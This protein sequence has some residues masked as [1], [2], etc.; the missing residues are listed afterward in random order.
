MDRIAAPNR[1]AACLRAITLV[2]LA[3]ATSA[4]SFLQS[5]HLLDMRQGSVRSDIVRQVS[6]GGYELAGGESVEFRDWYSPAFPDL[7]LSFLTKIGEDTGIIWGFSTGERGEKYRISPGLKLGFVHAIHPTSD[8][9]LTLTA[10]VQLGSRLRERTC[11]A[12]YGEVGG[13]ERVNCR[14]AASLIPPEETLRHR[15]AMDGLDD[16]RIALSYELRF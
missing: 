1:R 3:T 8:S 15:L 4:G 10:T 9:T 7:H 6:R 11:T 5:T 12:D 16:S 13:V 14:L 2:I